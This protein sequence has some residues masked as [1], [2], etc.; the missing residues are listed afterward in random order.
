MS[1]REPEEGAGERPERD[2]VNHR[3][4]EEWR[5]GDPGDPIEGG[6]QPPGEPEHGFPDYGPPLG[7]ARGHGD[8]SPDQPFGGPPPGNPP[9][10]GR[11]YGGPPP[12]GQ[13]S[14]GQPQ[15]GQPRYQPPGGHPTG[16]PPEPVDPGELSEGP[17][18]PGGA[19]PE[20]Q[21]YAPG[22]GEYP[23][24]PVE[25]GP[26]GGYGPPG[27]GGYGP[28]PPKP[29]PWGKIVG[30][31]CGVLLLLLL[32]LGG[33]AALLLV[34]ASGNL[35]GADGAPGTSQPG[36]EGQEEDEPSGA[37]VSANNTEFEPSSLYVSGDYT[38]VEV[39][40][41]N[42]GTDPL[43]INPLYFTVVD[44]EG[45]EHDPREAIAMDVNELDVQTLDPGQSASGAITVAGQVE[46]E[47]VLFEP[48]FTG[49]VEV[50]VA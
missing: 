24:E 3:P 1:E 15:Q 33:C 43:D 25:Y 10:T 5:P 32:V 30:I 27:Q 18:G 34:T 50:P 16:G 46:P 42:G 48:V 13:P 14:G 22:Y 38:S 26:P 21:G 11:P 45:V 44:V 6:P 36:S 2:P 41:T 20:H 8:P 31:S 39:S 35:P 40:V 47:R 49:P 28:P 17:S 9:P 4:P 19:G 7:E 29:A 12:E 23:S 37:E